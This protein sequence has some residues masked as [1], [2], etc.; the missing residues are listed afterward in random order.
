MIVKL[1]EI[2]DRATFIPAMTILL[3]N[4]DEAEFWLLRRAGYS[5]EAIG[6]RAGDVEPY[7]LLVKLDGVEAGAVSDGGDVD[8][9]RSRR[10]VPVAFCSIRSRRVSI[11]AYQSQ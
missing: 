4:R 6:G 9:H 2:R 1:I 5:A 3:R 7:V 8:A 10:V 11:F